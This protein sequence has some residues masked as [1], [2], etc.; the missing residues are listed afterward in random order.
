MKIPIAVIRR[1][2]G[3][4][5][6]YLDNILIMAGSKEELLILRDILF[7]SSRTWLFHQLQEV[8]VTPMPYIG[9]SGT[10]NRFFEYEGGTFQGESRKDKETMSIST[11]VRKVLSEGLIKVNGETL[12]YSNGSCASTFT[13]QGP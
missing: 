2:N 12:L 5:I 8:C 11:L 7:L 3:R 4:I 13:I 9:I 10:R 1:L 6:I